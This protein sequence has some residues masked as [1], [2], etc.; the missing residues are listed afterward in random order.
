MSDRLVADADYERAIGDRGTKPGTGTPKSGAKSGTSP[1][2]I[3]SHQ[4]GE[5]PE[6]PREVITFPSLSGLSNM[7]DRGLEPLTF[8]MPCKRSPN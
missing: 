2:N 7:E 5:S 6:K 4:N 3:V 1:A 8:C